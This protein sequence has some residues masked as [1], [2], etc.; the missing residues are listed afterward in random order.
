MKFCNRKAK[1][2]H[3]TLHK[4]YKFT[5]SL[6]RCKD[7]DKDGYQTMFEDEEEADELTESLEP[8]QLNG[9]EDTLI[10]EINDKE[11]S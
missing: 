8:F 1:Y 5:A 9:I 3:L 11:K 4:L 6:Q 2:F 7:V 10:D